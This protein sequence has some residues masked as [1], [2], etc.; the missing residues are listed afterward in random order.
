[1][2]SVHRPTSKP[3]NSSDFFSCVVRF[4]LTLGLQ[5]HR[6]GRTHPYQVVTNRGVQ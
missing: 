1:M 5:Y 4:A 2:Y 6:L 3:Y